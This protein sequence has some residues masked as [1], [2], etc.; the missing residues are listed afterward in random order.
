[1]RSYLGAFGFEGFF[2]AIER[3]QKDRRNIQAG[4][5]QSETGCYGVPD[6]GI[7]SIYDMLDFNGRFYRGRANE[8]DYVFDYT[9][10]FLF[11]AAKHEYLGKDIF[12]VKQNDNDYGALYKDGVKLTDDHF[13]SHM[14]SDF[15]KNEFAVFGYKEYSRACVLNT[16]GEV[17]FEH[18]GYGS[19]YITN[20]LVNA[21]GIYTNLLTK[22]VICTHKYGSTLKTDNNEFLFME[23]DSQVW[24]INTFTGE[25]EKFG[26]APEPKPA[27]VIASTAKQSPEEKPVILPKQGR[28]DL[29]RCGSGKKFKNCCINK[30]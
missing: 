17:V 5:Q 14:S 20:N 27:P 29:C 15:K 23:V 2:A 22:E 12:L 19:L 21:D 9:G 7:L 18:K 25:V 1:M 13:R 10:K 8:L 30:V 24:K 11:T 16:K 4:I 3:E 26:K 28:N 6:K